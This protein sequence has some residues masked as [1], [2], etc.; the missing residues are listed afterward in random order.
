MSNEIAAA[1]DGIRTILSRIEGL[2]I[3]D[4]TPEVVHQFPAAVVRLESRDA[5]ATLT[6]GAIR[7]SICVEIL[8]CG[9]DPRQMYKAL[10]MY[11]E[12]L[13]AHSIEAA[14]NADPTWGGSVD[15][16]RLTGVDNIGERR[17]GGV[18]CVGANFHFWFVVSA[19]G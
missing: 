1:L 16:G 17:Y 9:T 13:G 14:A 12:P 18:R 10:E 3:L 4:Y 7:G 11:T 5:L 19:G 8:V 6:G 2:R 15:D